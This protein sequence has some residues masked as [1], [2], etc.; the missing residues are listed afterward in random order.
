MSEE[1]AVLSARLRP[2]FLTA[3]RS[4]KRNTSSASARFKHKFD[5]LRTNGA[6]V[7]LVPLRSGKVWLQT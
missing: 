1:T 2:L 4:E 5:L 7:F 3:S 6:H